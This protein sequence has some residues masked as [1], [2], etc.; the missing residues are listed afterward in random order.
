M[1]HDCTSL[2]RA[3]T[4]SSV[5]NIVWTSSDKLINSYKWNWIGLKTYHGLSYSVI[6][7]LQCESPT[8]Q[9]CLATSIY[10]WKVWFFID[11]HYT[12]RPRS[13]FTVCP[14]EVSSRPITVHFIG[15]VGFRE[16]RQILSVI[17]ITLRTAGAIGNRA[18]CNPWIPKSSVCLIHHLK[19]VK[20]YRTTCVDH[21]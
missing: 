7:V 8:V 10:Q 17:Q 20:T 18:Y 12:P 1:Q 5:S 21:V 15:G 2:K 3:L 19:I 13:I 11:S 6:T 9:V 14:W 16:W 4:N